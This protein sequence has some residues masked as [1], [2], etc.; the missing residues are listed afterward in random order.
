MENKEETQNSNESLENVEKKSNN[1]EQQIPKSR[2]DEVNEKVKTLASK[3][4]EYETKEREASE[5]KMKE[6]GKYKELLETKENEIKTLRLETAK[7]KVANKLGLKGRQILL[8][9]RVKG[10]TEE[11]MTTDLKNLL[12]MTRGEDDKPES[13]DKAEDKKINGFSQN[14]DGNKNQKMDH[15]KLSSDEVLKIIGVSQ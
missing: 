1:T 13:S 12:D 4:A 8:L 14:P 10:E 5:I 7:Q 15:S 2:F 6:D 11:E 9:E 3:L